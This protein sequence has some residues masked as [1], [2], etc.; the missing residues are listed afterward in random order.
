MAKVGDY[1]PKGGQVGNYLESGWHQVV[2]DA[3]ELK[4]IGPKNTPLLEQSVFCA[5]TG[6]EATVKHWLTDKAMPRFARWCEVLGCDLEQRRSMDTE[7]ESTLSPIVGKCCWVLL[8]YKPGKN[9]NWYIEC[10]AFEPNGDKP[11]GGPNHETRPQPSG[12]RGGSSAGSGGGYSG[13][14]DEDDIPF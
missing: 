8:D 3:I 13:D 5:Q 9:G 7:D 1:E 6:K 2:T 12:G 10:V 14:V 11:E 4:T